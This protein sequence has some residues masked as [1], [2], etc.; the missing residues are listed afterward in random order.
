MTSSLEYHISVRHSIPAS[1]A[2]LSLLALPLFFVSTS[3]AQINGAPA[4]V[5]SP[6]FGGRA[7]NGTAPER[8][9]TR[10]SRLRSQPRRHLLHERASRNGDG[11]HHRH[12]VDYTVLP[13][14]TPCLFPTPSI[15]AQPTNN[16]ANAGRPRRELPGRPHDLRPPR[17][18]RRFLRPA[19][20]G[21]SH[22]SRRSGCRCR[23]CRSR[24]SASTDAARLQRR[25]Q[26]G[27][28]KLRHRRPDA[29]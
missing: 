16:D 19:G 22:A 7:V 12:H 15:S 24:T 21:C 23:T 20:E 8:H 10:P 6:G 3:H 1:L 14:S 27:S 5:T 13:W 29:L 25:S 2:L 17:I 28:R 11:H 9:F 18:R 26:A 4:S